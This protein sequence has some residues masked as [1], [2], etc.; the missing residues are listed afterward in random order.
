MDVSNRIVKINVLSRETGASLNPTLLFSTGRSKIVF[1]LNA[2]LQ[3]VYLYR[4]IDKILKLL[5]KFCST[6]LHV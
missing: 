1:R 4:I 5:N 3:T 6:E 2:W